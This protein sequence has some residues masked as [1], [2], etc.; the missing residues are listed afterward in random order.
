MIAED[1]AIS[2]KKPHGKN[3]MKVKSHTTNARNVNTYII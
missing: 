3:I 1:I 2:V